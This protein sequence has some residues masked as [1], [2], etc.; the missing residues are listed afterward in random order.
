MH[1][2]SPFQFGGQDALLIVQSDRLSSLGLQNTRKNG[3]DAGPTRFGTDTRSTA[4]IN[5]S[6]R[7]AQ[8]FA[9]SGGSS[10][11]PDNAEDY[12]SPQGQD[13]GIFDES[14]GSLSPIPDHDGTECLKWDDSLWSHAD[15]F[16]VG[17]PLLT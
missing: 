13:Q 5:K 14:L 2:T 1:C 16:R 9:A 7:V 15:H 8:Q 17:M 3:S 12:W 10:A 4:E 6:N 11:K